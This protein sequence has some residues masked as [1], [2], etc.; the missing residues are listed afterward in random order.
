MVKTNITRVPTNIELMGDELG[1]LRKS[2]EFNT[3]VFKEALASIKDAIKAK[4]PDAKIFN[5]INFNYIL[6]IDKKD[7]K[8]V[9]KNILQ[10]HVTHEN[11]LICKDVNKIIKKL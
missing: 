3:F 8:P 2:V 4:S 9:L 6:S 1:V 11:Y 10:F 7:F 5:I